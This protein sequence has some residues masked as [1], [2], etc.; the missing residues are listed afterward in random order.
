MKYFL[1]DWEDRIDPN[2]DF[3]NDFEFKRSNDPYTGRVYAH[4]IFEEPPYDGIL[5]SLAVFEDKIHL[6][7]SELQPLLRGKRNIKEYLRV[8][9]SNKKLLVMADCGAF[10]WVNEEVPPI[11]PSAVADVY[12][13]LGFDIGVSP[14]HIVVNSIIVQKG[15]KVETHQL[16]LE[17]KEKRRK[18]S[19]RNAERF[20]NYSETN[21]LCF[22]PMGSAQGYNSVTYLDSVNKLIDMGYKSIAIG[23]LARSSTKHVEEI[24][25][26]VIDQIDD[27]HAKVKVHLLGLLRPNLLPLFASLGVSSFDSASFLR[28]AWLR[29]NMNYLGADGKWYAA[30]R[31]PYSYDDR[32]LAEAKRKRISQR[33]L[34]QLERDALRAM[35]DFGK[36]KLSLKKTIDA[37]AEYDKLLERISPDQRSIN[38]EYEATLRSRIWER[39]SCVICQ[40]VGV[41]VVLFRGANRNKRRGFHNTKMF[42]DN[43]RGGK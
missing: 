31:I 9:E 20:L 18:L 11:K 40:Q 13:R 36:R 37:V 39:C 29:S 26:A 21:S 32:V 14:D 8:K 35:S 2:F 22:T 15:D 1:P 41:Q 43:Y 10:T 23:G 28:K 12:D 27:R 42:Y 6:D 30:I 5:I 7:G 17:E 38:A 25:K 34:E 33:R 19:L 16:T 24:V 3:E 4:E